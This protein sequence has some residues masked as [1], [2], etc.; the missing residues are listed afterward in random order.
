MRVTKKGLGISAVGLLIASFTG[1]CADADHD[2]WR[3]FAGTGGAGG[4]ES[5]GEPAVVG[6]TGGGEDGGSS[7]GEPPVCPDECPSPPPCPDCGFDTCEGGEPMPDNC[8]PIWGTEPWEA[9]WLW[10]HE[11][12]DGSTPPAWSCEL[13]IPD[14]LPPGM[15]DTI[16]DACNDP[17]IPLEDRIRCAAQ[18]VD[19][20][21]GGVGE[22][23]GEGVCRH[24]A[25]ALDN[26]LGKMGIDVDWA[27][28]PSHAWNEVPIDDDGDGNP[29]RIIII[30]SYND[31]YMECTVE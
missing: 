23:P 18:S 17:A 20:A 10:C 31:V 1:G 8:T 9:Q 30:D 6:T 25:A 27:L 24:H 26:V 11:A 5:W 21:L 15:C 16:V 3:L 12:N 7:T 13:L 29:D 19:A 4:T 22:T 28:S 2:D 14:M